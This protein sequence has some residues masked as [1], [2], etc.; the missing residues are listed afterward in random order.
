MAGS[1]QRGAA[2]GPRTA[3]EVTNVSKIYRRYSRRRQFATLKSALLSRSL[4]R[5]L[6]PDET[7]PAL[8]DV[9][10]TVDITS[11]ASAEDIA[12]LVETVNAH[13]PV[14][15]ILQQPVPVHGDVRLNGAPIDA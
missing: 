8:K 14:L 3:I 4:V 10:F 6:A 11:P 13:C 15:D 2:S 7:F 5:D 9:T 1:E 12:R